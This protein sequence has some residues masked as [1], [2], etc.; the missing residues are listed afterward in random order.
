MLPDIVDHVPEDLRRNFGLD[1]PVPANLFPWHWPSNKSSLPG[2]HGPLWRESLTYHV[3]VLAFTLTCI[4]RT[5]QLLS[6]R[7][8]PATVPKR[9]G[10]D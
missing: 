4:V 8:Q 3:I 7:R 5:R 9:G 6:W 2:L 10:G 1:V